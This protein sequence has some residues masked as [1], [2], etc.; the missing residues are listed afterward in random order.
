MKL[1]SHSEYVVYRARKVVSGKNEL[2]DDN[3]NS[4]AKTLIDA[5]FKISS[6]STFQWSPDSDRLA[7]YYRTCDS[8]GTCLS[9]IR[10]CDASGN[11]EDIFSV[12]RYYDFRQIEWLTMK[13]RFGRRKGARS[14]WLMLLRLGIIYSCRPFRGPGFNCSR[15]KVHRFQ[16]K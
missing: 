16:D 1:V 15:Q 8:G 3:S 5:D 12:N 10:L 14:G 13:A 4:T 6:Y 11:Q 2:V 9:K 7:Q